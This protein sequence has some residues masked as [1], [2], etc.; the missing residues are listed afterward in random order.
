ML[1]KMPPWTACTPSLLSFP[2][3][4]FLH[5]RLLLERDFT[6]VDTVASPQVPALSPPHPQGK[7]SVAYGSVAVV[8]LTM[9]REETKRLL[10]EWS[11][12]SL[13]PQSFDSSFSA[14]DE[15]T[16]QYLVQSSQ[17]ASFYTHTNMGESSSSS[18][19]TSRRFNTYASEVTSL[20][21]STATAQYLLYTSL[22]S[23]ASVT[24]LLDQVFV[25][26]VVI[27]TLVAAY[28]IYILLLSSLKDKLFTITFSLMHSVELALLRLVGLRKT[29]AIS[30]LLTQLLF[31]TLPGILAG[32]L[33]SLGL[34]LLLAVL[35]N[36]SLLLDLPLFPPLSSYLLSAFIGLLSPLLAL[37]A[38]ALSF[39][40]Q[41]LIDAIDIQHSVGS[42]EFELTRRV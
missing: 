11:Q 5:S 6:I 16:M 17:H 12:Q 15:L 36:K 8:S 4:H 7:W 1:L 34:Y 24:V 32:L 28:V 25:M 13:T 23:L 29:S 37:A 20:L 10:R 26:I 31:F 42:P 18:S 22:Q 40:K 27:I 19:F 2:R 3:L 33:L 41:K 9:L 14:V 39:L 38:P 21:P 30:I 35:F